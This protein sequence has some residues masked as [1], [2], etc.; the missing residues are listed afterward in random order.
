M[1]IE[2]KI[3]KTTGEIIIK[4]FLRG[5]LLGK[6]AFARC[7]EVTESTTKKVYAAKIISKNILEKNKAR[8][9]VECVKSS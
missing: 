4:R 1:A 2:E 8:Q 6:G 9:K 3:Q 5:K 7:Y